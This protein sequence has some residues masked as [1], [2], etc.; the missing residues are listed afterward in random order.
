MSILA[1]AVGVFEDTADLN[2]RQ[3]RPRSASIRSLHIAVFQG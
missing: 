3:Y 1:T 2:G